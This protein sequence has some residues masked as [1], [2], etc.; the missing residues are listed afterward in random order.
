LNLKGFSAT[1]E[2]TVTANFTDGA[3]NSDTVESEI[4]ALLTTQVTSISISRD[5]PTVFPAVDGYI[6]SVQLPFTMETSTGRSIPLTKGSITVK[7]GSK[8]AQ[9][10]PLTKSASSYKT[11]N[12]KNGG[13]IVPGSYTIVMVAQGAEGRSLTSTAVVVVSDKKMTTKTTTVSYTGKE[14]FR[15]Y[16]SYDDTACTYSGTNFVGYTYY[17]DSALCYSYLTVPSAVV[18]GFSYGSVSVKATLDVYDNIGS[19]CGSFGIYETSGD[20]VLLCAQWKKDHEHGALGSGYD[21][22][23]DL[24]LSTRCVGAVERSFP[25]PDLYL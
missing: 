21:N 22:H 10:W 14:A 23:P 19:Y 24:H 4:I 18:R 3:G 1:D 13:K 2:A 8:V 6:D 5:V 11:W 17:I 20:D 25:K 12:G 7:L 15:Y 16:D 9:T